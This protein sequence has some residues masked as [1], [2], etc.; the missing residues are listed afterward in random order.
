MLQEQA[1]SYRSI[2]RIHV[3]FGERSVIKPADASRVP[4]AAML[5]IEQFVATP[6]RE[7]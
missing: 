7:A 6:V 1:S 2:P 5:E 3:H 4:N